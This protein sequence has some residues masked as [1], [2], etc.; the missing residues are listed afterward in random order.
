MEPSLLP[1]PLG[2]QSKTE[3]KHRL[4]KHRD[5]VGCGPVVDAA[6]RRR[7]SGQLASEAGPVV[8]D[9]SS[10][11]IDGESIVDDPISQP[12]LFT[13]PATGETI[14]V[15]FELPPQ[16]SALTLSGFR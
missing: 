9:G 3:P 15:V 1:S 11:T 12:M 5:D 13:D 4:Q 8:V 2:W 7:G 16:L 10:V 14:I 6:G